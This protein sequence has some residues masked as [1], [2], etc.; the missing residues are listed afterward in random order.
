MSHWGRLRTKIDTFNASSTSSFNMASVRDFLHILCCRSSDP[1][2]LTKSI[3]MMKTV[4][5]DDD[6]DDDASER[7]TAA[8]RK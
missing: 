8:E 4:T 3:F 5:A 2:M 6:A 1:T 7:M